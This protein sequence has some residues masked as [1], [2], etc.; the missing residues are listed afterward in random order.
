MTANLKA[1]PR[2]F[3]YFRKSQ[4]AKSVRVL[5]SGTLI[6]QLINSLIAPLLTRLYAPAD[7]GLLSLLNSLI[8][9]LTLVSAFRYELAIPMADTE[10]RALNLLIISIL[11]VFVSVFVVGMV[12]WSAPKG[13][14]KIGLSSIS[15]YALFVVVGLLFSGVFNALLYWCIRKKRFGIVSN[16]RIL[17]SASGGVIQVMLGILHFQ[18]IGLLVGA[19]AKQIAGAFILIFSFFKNDG[20]TQKIEAKSL[21]CT[22]K[23]YRKF[24]LFSSW[25]A[26]A[27]NL[28]NYLPFFIIA[29]FF[30][31]EKLGYYSL[32][33]MVVGMPVTILGQAVSQVYLSTAK[34]YAENPA[35]VKILFTKAARYL[36]VTSLA[37]FAA[38]FLTAEMIFPLL[39]GHSWYSSGLVVKNL[40]ALFFFQ[41]IA[42]PLSTNLTL[43]NRQ[44]IQLAW[45]VLRLLIML[46]SLIIPASL[47]ISF[48]ATIKIFAVS[49]SLMYIL[50]YLT[51][52]Y[53]LNKS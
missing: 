51:N 15:S 28:G 39:F 3:S 30:G 10:N 53:F 24:P 52:I 32:A 40:T 41:F 35:Q 45:D 31:A 44:E 22:M 8:I 12:L 19:L 21:I 2:L 1:I 38:L 42:V 33:I 9:I 20:I 5:A 37:I 46:G 49:L 17:Q 18:S 25:A 47:G 11:M 6:S 4:F 48:F 7:I 27:N 14:D 26:L 36:L 16:S 23:K 13:L 34:I 43:L 50:L 29:K